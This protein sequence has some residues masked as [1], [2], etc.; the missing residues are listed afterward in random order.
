MFYL[1]YT[2]LLD[3]MAICV[4]VVRLMQVVLAE[5]I[6]LD[7]LKWKMVSQQTLAEKLQWRPGTT[8]K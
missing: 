6:Q 1:G 8:T 3:L 2:L 4:Y 5:T 7:L